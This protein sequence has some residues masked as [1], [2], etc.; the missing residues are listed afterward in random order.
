MG[1]EAF[2]DEFGNLNIVGRV[3]EQI[4]LK[5]T[6]KSNC[7]LLE[8]KILLSGCKIKEAVVLNRRNSGSRA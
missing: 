6:K 5:S 4:I 2:L 8:E 1:D 7:S 3:K